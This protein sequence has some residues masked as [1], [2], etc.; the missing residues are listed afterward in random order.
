MRKTFLHDSTGFTLLEVLIGLVV[1]AV[2]ILGINAM[3][4]SS[5]KGN[6]KGRQ[7][8]EAT[9]VAARQVETI[10]S[11]EY[12][13]APLVDD[14]D[15]KDDTD[16]DGDIDSGDGT[17]QD[18]DNDGVDD[19]GGDFGL[20]DKTNP[21]GMI[22]DGVY[23]IYWNVAVD[24]PLPNTKTIRVIVDSQRDISDIA[25]TFVRYRLSN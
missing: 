15:G 11:W 23:T 21:D 6:S 3:Q 25:M 17:D 9:N 7:V 14:D 8:S 18:L 20:N 22:T 1:F 16:A 24:H 19:D 12:D 2:G 4:V 5:I 10:L 13:S